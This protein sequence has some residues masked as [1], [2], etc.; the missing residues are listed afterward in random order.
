MN[1][2]QRKL[3]TPGGVIFRVPNEPLALAVAQEW[4]VQGD[5]IKRQNMHIVGLPPYF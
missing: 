1:L 3:R 5:M 2:D 4:K